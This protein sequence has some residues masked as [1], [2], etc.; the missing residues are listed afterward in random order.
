MPLVLLERSWWAGFNWIYF[1]IQNVRKIFDFELIS[2][3][4]KI[5]INSKKSGFAKE[6]SVEDVIKL[7]PMAHATLQQP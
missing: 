6:K 5:Q 2:A 3:I 4:E 1:G 7:E